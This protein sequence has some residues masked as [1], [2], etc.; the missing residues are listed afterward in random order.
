MARE[1]LFQK[2]I[3]L[4]RETT[5]YQREKTQ[6]RDQDF[7][8]YGEFGKE[9]REN[10]QRKTLELWQDNIMTLAEKDNKNWQRNTVQCD[11]TVKDY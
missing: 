3:D 9:R 7:A 11:W 6:W 8:G 10:L 5:A 4:V 1:Q 2:N